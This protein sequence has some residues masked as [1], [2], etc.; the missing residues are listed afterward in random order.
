VA[1]L[2]GMVPK[3]VRDLDQ[4]RIGVRDV[5]VRRSTLDDVFFALTGHAA[6]EDSENGGDGEDGDTTLSD[7]E[8][9]EQEANPR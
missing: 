3:V 1:S 2:D 4:A 5:G 6:E 8:R 7:T 9:A